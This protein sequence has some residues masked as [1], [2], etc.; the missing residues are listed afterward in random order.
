MRA[1]I[2]A[3]RAQVEQR[4]REKVRAALDAGAHETTGT[5]LQP[6]ASSSE[7]LAEALDEP[8]VVARLM[9][10]IRS[11][12]SRTVARG[13]LQD[14]LSGEQVSLVARGNSPLELALQLT[15]ALVKAPLG[16][17][18]VARTLLKA[19]AKAAASPV[20]TEAPKQEESK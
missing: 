11:D 6:R 13:M 16:A 3:L 19:R 8:P 20:A 10:E 18:Q 1:R 7:E 2:Q 4:V 14:E 15:R 9:V 5:E 12:G 17:G